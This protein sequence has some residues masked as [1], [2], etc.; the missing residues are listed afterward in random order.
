M[1]AETGQPGEAGDETP[2]LNKPREQLLQSTKQDGN[3]A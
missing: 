1:E 2:A 3:E